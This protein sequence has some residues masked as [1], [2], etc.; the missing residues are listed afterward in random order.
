MKAVI[1]AGG[2]GTR[3]SEESHLKPKPMIEIGNDPILWHIMK[4]YSHYGI[5]DFIICAGYKQQIIKEYFANYSLHRSDVTF[6]LKNNGEITVHSNVS[7]P[8]N[9]T[10]VDTGYNTMTGGRVKRIKPYVGD[11]TF[12]LTY[13]DG[14]SDVNID[15]LIKFHKDH[16]KALTVTAINPGQRFGVLAVGEDGNVN[17]FHEKRD[18]DGELI[19]GGF[20]VVEPEVF[21]YIDGDGTFF[22]KE[23]VECLVKE[24]K[25]A[26]Y[27]HE[28]FWQ[29]MD[30]QRD[31]E[32][33]EMLLASGNAPWVVWE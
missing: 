8:W 19:N 31:K 27:R 1:L 2:F 10:V 18:S 3:I 5:N 12:L 20:M 13:G 22:E 21:D 33:L 28:G 14:V 6:N 26:A 29:C 17:S 11:E 4:L 24:G 32:R 15:E 25:V 9:V 7:E 23:P 30:T 16:K